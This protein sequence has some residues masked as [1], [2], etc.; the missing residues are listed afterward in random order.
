MIEILDRA[1]MDD[2][3]L[4]YTPIDV[5]LKLSSTGVPVSNLMDFCSL[6]GAL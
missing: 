2:C 3:Q 4:C 6:V 1:R 5:N